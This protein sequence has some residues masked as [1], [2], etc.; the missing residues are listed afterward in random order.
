[1]NTLPKETL[2]LIIKELVFVQDRE[3][4][5]FDL[6]KIAMDIGVNESVVREVARNYEDYQKEI[7]IF[8]SIL[9]KEIATK[10]L[11]YEATAV[12]TDD[13]MEIAEKYQCSFWNIKNFY[14]S[15]YFKNDY[16][17]KDGSVR[18]GILT[19]YKLL[20]EAKNKEQVKKQNEF[21]L[22]TRKNKIINNETLQ[23]FHE[24]LNEERLFFLM[25]YKNSKED[26]LLRDFF[27]TSINQIKKLRKHI[28]L[29][30]NQKVVIDDKI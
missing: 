17:F 20:T 21:S 7:N 24:K 12:S 1:M 6:Y 19:M 2:Q 9:I 18:Y 25:Q 28:N 26:I 14:G 23:L 27:D 8:T 29:I 30:L 10:M 3:L 13:L 22:R 11:Q 15:E 16:I 4:D 5:N